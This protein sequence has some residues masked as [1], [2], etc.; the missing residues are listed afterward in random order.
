MVRVERTCWVFS[1]MDETDSQ[2][3]VKKLQTI[4]VKEKILQSFREAYKQTGTNKR[5]GIRKS[6]RFLVA[7][8]KARKQQRMTFKFWRW[9]IFNLEFYA[10]SNYKSRV[11]V[12][13]R[14]FGYKSYL[15]FTSMHSLINRGNYWRIY[16]TKNREEAKSISRTLE[17]RATSPNSTR[18][19]LWERLFK[20]ME[21]MAYIMDR[22]VLRD[23]LPN[24]SWVWY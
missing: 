15:S 17:R 22:V 12:K 5:L 3:G 1:T 14:Y 4:G 20:E 11:R 10:Q 9:M 24:W 6:F 13:S 19:R 23:D 21:L 7:T 18:Q 2:L 8:Q 16:S